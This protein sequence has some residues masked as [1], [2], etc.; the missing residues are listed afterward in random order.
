MIGGNIFIY[1]L[2]ECFRMK[3]WTSRHDILFITGKEVYGKK[4]TIAVV[5]TWQKRKSTA[6]AVWACPT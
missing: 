2:S 4:S 3:V 6:I 5:S 1:A